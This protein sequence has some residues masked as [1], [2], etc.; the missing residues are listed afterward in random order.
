MS[1]SVPA[2]VRELLG[3][4]TES[5]KWNYRGVKAIEEKDYYNAVR[6]FEKAL[7]LDPKNANAKKNKEKVQRLIVPQKRKTSNDYKARSNNKKGYCSTKSKYEAVAMLGN[8]Y[9]VKNKETRNM[10]TVSPRISN[11]TIRKK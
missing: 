5:D 3:L 7:Q 1:N 9:V 10:L 2:L 4:P 11:S 6:M 8:N